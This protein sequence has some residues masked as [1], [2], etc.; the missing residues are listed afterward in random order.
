[1]TL[2]NRFIGTSPNIC[3][4]VAKSATASETAQLEGLESVISLMDSAPVNPQWV[5]ILMLEG[6][7]PAWRDSLVSLQI[8]FSG[9]RIATAILVEVSTDLARTP[10]VMWTVVSANARMECVAGSA[11]RCH[12]TTT[13]HSSTSSN[14]RL[15]TDTDLMV[16]KLSTITSRQSFQTSPGEAMLDS[17]SSKMRFCKISHWK[18]HQPTTQC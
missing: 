14:M 8:I 9:A 6:A 4:R 13:S 18:R 10:L 17:H 11:R 1:V 5:E 12:Q 2:A 16:A 3:L 7:Q 15:R